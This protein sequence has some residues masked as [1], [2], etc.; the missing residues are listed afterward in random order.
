ME[1]YAFLHL[2]YVLFCCYCS[3][4]WL[5]YPVREGIKTS[6]CGS[7]S[8]KV[9]NSSLRRAAKLAQSFFGAEAQDPC[10]FSISLKA[11][12]QHHANP[13]VADTPRGREAR[14]L[15]WCHSPLTSP[16]FRRHCI[17]NPCL[18]AQHRSPLRAKRGSEWQVTLGCRR[19]FPGT[20]IG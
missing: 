16:S 2:D 17:H 13:R 5:G 10:Y 8:G 12:S 14:L 18:A 1:T 4:C 9:V 20:Q 19:S 15:P 6:V 11:A 3:F 7:E